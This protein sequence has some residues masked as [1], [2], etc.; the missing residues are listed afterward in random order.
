MNR[1]ISSTHWWNRHVWMFFGRI[2][3]YYAASYFFSLLLLQACY[4]HAF[5]VKKRVYQ[6]CNVSQTLFPFWKSLINGERVYYHCDMRKKGFVTR[7]KL[8]NPFFVYEG[9]KNGFSV[10]YSTEIFDIVHMFVCCV[11]SLLLYAFSL[12]FS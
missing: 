1:A 9:V 10:Y 3:F 2:H 5:T 11:C 4:W 6:F 12:S 7:C 8:I